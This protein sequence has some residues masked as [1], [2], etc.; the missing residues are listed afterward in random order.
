MGIYDKFHRVHAISGLSLNNAPKVNDANNYALQGNTPPKKTICNCKTHSKARNFR[1]L[2]SLVKD[3]EEIMIQNKLTELGDRIN[4]IRGIYYGTTWSLDYAQEKSDSRN[5]GFYVYT[6]LTNVKHD[7]RKM[8]K[9]S[10][11]CKGKLFEALYQSPE[12][13]DSSSMVTDFG[14]LMIGLDARRSY[15]A[16]N[17]NLPYGGTGLENVTWIGDIGGGTGMLAYKRTT[18]PNVRAKKIVF[19]S[20]H[21]YGCSINIE[22]DIAAY[23]VGLNYKDKDGW[24][25]ISNP[26]DELEYIYKG[27]EDYFDKSKGW[28][29]RVNAFI[30]QIGGEIEN[31][32]LTNKED[33]LEDIIDS[34]EGMSQFYISLRAKDKSYNYQNLLKS[35]GYIK[36]CSKEVSEIFLEGLLSLRTHPNSSKYVATKDINP[37]VVDNSTIEEGIKKA[38]IIIE[39]VSKLF[40]ELK[41]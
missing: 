28:T 29:L 22:G 14:H 15:I 39:K 30:T 41:K 12:V 27:L 7:A 3:A 9:C 18:D 17:T 13:V 1:D 38:K 2:I 8:L 32:V 20:A 5:Y 34:V 16:K 26:T 24:K 11:I 10:D 23:I 36:S 40:D 31:G 25:E 6:G 19:D 4:C 37:T 21:D 35:F 33:L